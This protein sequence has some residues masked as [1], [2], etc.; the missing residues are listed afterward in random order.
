MK[1]KKITILKLGG[2]LLTDKLTPYKLREDILDS[3]ALELSECLKLGLI[4]RLLVIHGVGSFGH[5]PVIEYKLYEGFKDSNQ[6]INLSKTQYLVNKL[7]TKIVDS[8]IKAGIPVNLMYI[9]SMLVRKEG[10]ISGFAFDALKGFF[11]LG[12]VPLLGGDVIYDE[13][14]GFS[15]CGGD[16]FAAHITRELG[17]N[18]LIF[19]TD[20][21]GVYD[22][23]PKL[24]SDAEMIKEISINTIEGMVQGME[25]TNKKDI[26]GRMKGKLLSIVPIKDLIKKGL[27]VS[28][29]SMKTPNTL[30]RFLEGNKNLA[31][32]I[33]Y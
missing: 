32:R 26:T 25:D 13:E 21:E 4:E 19:A 6:L 22:R 20:V 23:D 29:L 1:K 33:N 28:I 8:F 17:A 9:S 24:Y 31:T 18:Q 10:K 3:I 14:I 16:L 2:S 5:P 11:S 7:R 15:V 27:K 12:M 30:K